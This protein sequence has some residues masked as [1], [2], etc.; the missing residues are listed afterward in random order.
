MAWDRR[1]LS[2]RVWQ[3]WAWCRSLSTVAVARVLGISSSN[4]AGCRFELIDGAFLVGGVDQAV[5]PFGGVRA[6]W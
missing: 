3:R 5:E 4:P 6:D 2:P 1:T